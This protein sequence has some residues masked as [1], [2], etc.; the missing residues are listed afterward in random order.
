MPKTAAGP[1]PAR[2]ATPREPARA[3]PLAHF[4]PRRPTGELG[5]PSHPSDEI[6][7][8][9]PF[10]VEQNSR[11]DRSD[12]NPSQF[13]PA[14]AARFSASRCA[15]RSRGRSAT[16]PGRSPA[17]A[18]TAIAPRRAAPPFP[19]LLFSP[20]PCL[21]FDRERGTPAAPSSAPLALRRRPSLWSSGGARLRRPPASA[22][23]HRTARA[24]S[25]FPFFFSSR[26]LPRTATERERYGGF[27]MRRPC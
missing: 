17:T 21:S 16:A 23:N 10:S 2:L 8:P 26:L 22:A 9:A 3:Q 5:F 4:R 11:P 18:S 13:P 14:R 25:P 12:R 20:F 6:D 19:F 1:R 15:R 7:G 24:A 27:P